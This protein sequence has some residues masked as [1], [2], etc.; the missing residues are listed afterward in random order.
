MY[1]D[2]L[3]QK[4]IPGGV[5]AFVHQSELFIGT[6]TVEEHL[7]FQALL[8]MRSDLTHAQKLSRVRDV[9]TE[10][11]LEKCRNTLIGVGDLFCKFVIVL[12]WY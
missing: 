5:S 12:Y 7:T 6:L 11:G 3:I 9:I 10:L 2:L 1:Q 8:R 4:I